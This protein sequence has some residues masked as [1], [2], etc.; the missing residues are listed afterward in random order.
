MKQNIIF[1]LVSSTIANNALA[2]CT[3]NICTDVY[4]DRMYTNTTGLV[5][6]ATSGDE[7]KLDCSPI[8]D[9]Y[10]SFTLDEPA[11][12]AIYSTLLAAQ[13]AD[14]RVRIRIF[15]GSSKCGIQYITHDRQ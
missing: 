11:G 9:V 3:S 14:R 8:S 15:D 1:A 5:Y 2:T 7:T 6:V 13:M 12:D 10:L 4:V